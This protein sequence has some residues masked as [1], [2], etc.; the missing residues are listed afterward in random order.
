MLITKRSVVSYKDHTLDI[1]ITQA[2]YD[3]WQTGTLIQD[4]MPNLSPGQREFLITGITPSE[5]DSIF[6]E[7]D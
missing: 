4:C 1:P 3:Q 2:Q 5:W 7:D 6:D